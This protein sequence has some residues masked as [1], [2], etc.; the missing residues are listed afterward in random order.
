[1][2]SKRDVTTIL[3]AGPFLCGRDL[4]HRQI[5]GFDQFLR[6]SRQTVCAGEVLEI[7]KYVQN[8]VMLH[9]QIHP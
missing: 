3:R 7:N 4:D 1:M 8:P 9:G 5:G 2:D 6:N